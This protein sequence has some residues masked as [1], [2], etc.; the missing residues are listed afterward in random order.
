MTGS[1]LQR[2]IFGETLLTT[3][4]KAHSPLGIFYFID[5]GLFF[6]PLSIICNDIFIFNMSSLKT[7]YVSVLFTTAH[8]ALTVLA[9]GKY[10]LSL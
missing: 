2:L 8:P 1:Q 9:H 4:N 6:M 5:Q 7:R 10:L 3:L